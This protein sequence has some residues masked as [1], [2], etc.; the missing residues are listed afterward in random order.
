MKNSD[1]NWLFKMLLSPSKSQKTENS[2]NEKLGLKKPWFNRD[3]LKKTKQNAMISTGVYEITH[4]VSEDTL[5]NSG[6]SSHRLVQRYTMNRSDQHAFYTRRMTKPFYSI[7]EI[8][9]QQNQ[10]LQLDKTTCKYIERLRRLGFSKVHIRQDKNLKAHMAYENPKEM[11][12][13]LEISLQ[14]DQMPQNIRRP[15]GCDLPSSLPLRRTKW[16][17]TSYKTGIAYLPYWADKDPCYDTLD[18]HLDNSTLSQY[19]S[20]EHIPS[21]HRSLYYT[22]PYFSS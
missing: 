20:L 11:D 10:W 13:L 1:Y 3:F 22:E 21:Q 7:Y 8:E 15:I 18:F 17:F 9:W 19:P 14:C 4:S 16:W 5:K 6:K 12:I 2:L